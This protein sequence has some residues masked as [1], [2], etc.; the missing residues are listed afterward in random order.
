MSPKRNTALVTGGGGFLGTA[1]I[2]LLV[3]KGVKVRSL[4]RN[5][6]TELDRL[7]VEQVQ[8]DLRDARLVQRA[9]QGM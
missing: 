9:C 3:E 2:R 8:G 4:A 1:I 5:R 7:A 6:Y